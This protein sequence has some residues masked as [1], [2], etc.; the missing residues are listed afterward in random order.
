MVKKLP[1]ALE[2]DIYSLGEVFVR[3][4]YS[5]YATGREIRQF[6]Q[7]HG[8]DAPSV[9]RILAS[10]MEP[11]E[12]RCA[13]ANVRDQLRKLSFQPLPSEPRPLVTSAFLGIGALVTAAV[14]AQ[15]ARSKS[16]RRSQS[17]F[18]SRSRLQ[19]EFRVGRTQGKRTYMEDYYCHSRVAFHTTPE[20]R[21]WRIMG[22]FDGH[23]GK[24]CAKFA[25]RFLPHEVRRMLRTAEEQL[26]GSGGQ[27]AEVMRVAAQAL[28]SALESLNDLFVK[29][30]KRE[31]GSRGF[32]YPG[33]TA[34]AAL[35]SPDGSH[36]VLCNIGDARAALTGDWRVVEHVGY[37]PIVS[38]DKHVILTCPHTPGDASEIQR[39]EDAG[40]F[41]EQG[42][43]GPR[44]NGVLGV[45]RAIGYAGVAEFQNVVPAVADYVIAERVDGSAA[46]GKTSGF[47]SMV[48]LAT[49]GVFEAVGQD[50][51]DSVFRRL[52]EAED[53]E[54]LGAKIQEE[55][56]SAGGGPGC[57]A[58]NDDN[59]TLLA[60]LLPAL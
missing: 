2:D 1:Y 58:E 30:K 47:V 22:M 15:Q 50:Q 8:D 26:E 7:K 37:P 14:V 10:M 33:T 17:V 49:D 51:A 35:L 27:Q 53:G 9:A 56:D 11:R 24:D 52:A 4:L 39:I 12:S 29:F 55:L 46:A 42:A 16:L 31:V 13:L 38:E 25:A 43:R 59:A 45:A 21:S 36:A 48:A 34:A 28:K 23:G 5:S 57:A 32:G 18:S 19:A 6:V 60:C 41:V 20:A 44:V 40:G 54:A 3:I